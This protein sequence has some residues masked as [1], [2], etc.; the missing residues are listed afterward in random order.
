MDQLKVVWNQIVKYHFWILT[1]LVLLLSLIAFLFAKSS[2]REQV[3]GRVSA[4]N[5]SFNTV[6]SLQA[7]ASSH[8]NSASEAEM[9]KILEGTRT[10]VFEAWKQQY[11]RQSK[12]LVWPEDVLDPDSPGYKKLDSFRPFEKDL[13]YP[14]PTNADPLVVTD[15]EIYRNYIGGVFGRLA[16]TIGA[17]WTAVLGSGAASSEGG[18][19]DFTGVDALATASGPAPLVSW[20]S[21]SQA[22]LQSEI[23][24]WYK[25]TQAPSTLDI[26]YTQEDLWILAAI[27]DVIKKTNG[28]AKENFQAPI[29]MIEVIKIGKYASGDT[30]AMQFG[31]GDG[32]E[33]FSGDGTGMPMA[34]ADPAENRYVDA[35]YKPIPGSVLREKTKSTSPDDAF[36]FVAKRVPVRF[37]LRM[38]QSK[39]AKLLSECGNGELMVEVK[40]VRV[41][42]S[43]SPLVLNLAASPDAMLTGDATGMPEGE[44]FDPSGGGIDFGG[45]E[46]VEG[47]ASGEEGEGSMLLG[48]GPDTP[49]EVY[50]IVHLF[51]PPDKVKLGLDQPTTP[52]Q[53]A[54]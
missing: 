21:A 37:R 35:N 26:C 40:Q 45:G 2:L 39:I 38:D 47:E 43:T 52:P 7:K 12:I 28:N 36:Y 44:A 18:T 8:P 23:V 5:N 19:E 27:L 9:N 48:P 10:N 32:T 34:S 11:D 24:H 25:P 46:G 51:N 50:G 3:D 6:S 33:D 54:P 16:K 29:K 20:S 1:S 41:N 53:G 22:T 13:V 15:R 49:V 31:S 30:S 17:N 14:M 42:A 4:L